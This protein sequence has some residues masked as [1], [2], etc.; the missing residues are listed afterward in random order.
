M[1][2][3]GRCKCGSV[4]FQSSSGL[5]GNYVVCDGCHMI[6]EVEEGR[7]KKTKLT[8]TDEALDVV[9]AGMDKMNR[10]C[11]PEERPESLLDA[12]LTEQ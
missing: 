12:M 5:P 2:E 9:I 11:D 6:W 1:R 8:F 4:R 10:A 7:L 3:Y